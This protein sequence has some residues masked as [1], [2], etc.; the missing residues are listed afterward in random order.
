MRLLQTYGNGCRPDTPYE[1]TKV[2]WRATF[3]LRPCSPE[4]DAS[5][6]TAMLSVGA[7]LPNTRIN[8]DGG[9]DIWVGGGTGVSMDVKPGPHTVVAH[10]PDGRSHTES[11]VLGAGDRRDISLNGDPAV[12]SRHCLQVPASHVCAFTDSG[13]RAWL[14]WDQSATWQWDMFPSGE[15][16]LFWSSSEDGA[17]WSTPRRLPVSSAT[18]D[19][20]PAICQDRAGTYW[21]A[22]LSD[23]DPDQPR[24]PW[25]ASSQD[26][27]EWSFPRKVVLPALPEGDLAVWRERHWPSLAFTVDRSDTFWLVMQG[28][29]FRSQ[30][31]VS[32]QEAEVLHTSDSRSADNRIGYID[33]RLG[34]GPGGRLLLMAYGGLG[35]AKL[36]R[37]RRRL[38]QG[39]QPLAQGGEGDGRVVR[40]RTGRRRLLGVRGYQRHPPAHAR[41]RRLVEGRPGPHPCCRHVAPGRHRSAGR[42]LRGGV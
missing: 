23:R 6:P 25:I 26:G 16:N 32:W 3:A 21:L 27:V 7:S 38:A 41:R 31:A 33:Y 34:P 37:P 17:E 30:D 14:V 18:L 24:W 29:L 15:S 35:D 9:H 2:P 28:R 11:V 1:A 36:L 42:A 8:V 39:R 19:M 20:L 4:E 40:L 12:R 13:G 5:A 10:W 22:W